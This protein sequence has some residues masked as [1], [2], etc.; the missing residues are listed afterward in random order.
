MLRQ[1]S[2][3]MFGRHQLGF[4]DRHIR[5]SVQAGWSGFGEVCCPHGSTPLAKRTVSRRDRCIWEAHHINHI[6]ARLFQAHFCPKTTHLYSEN[7]DMIA[8]HLTPSNPEK[9]RLEYSSR[10]G[11]CSPL[12]REPSPSAKHGTIGF[13]NALDW[14][15]VR[16]GPRPHRLKY[17]KALRMHGIEIQTAGMRKRLLIGAGLLWQ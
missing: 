2:L 16:A 8:L 15:N 1:L 5:S 3:S 7:R 12:L 11:Q 14:S 4:T 9:L 13:G 6:V 17:F 10:Y